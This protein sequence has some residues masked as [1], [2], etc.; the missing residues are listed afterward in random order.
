[1][2]LIVHRQARLL[3]SLQ[4][5]DPAT[6]D[7]SLPGLPLGTTLDPEVLHGAACGENDLELFYPEPGDQA[8]KQA[9]K[10]IC[11]ACPVKDACLEMALAIGDQHAILG[12]TTPAERV[13]MRCC[14][15]QQIH[16]REQAAEWATA[17]T[18]ID[19]GELRA[20]AG[21]SMAAHLRGDASATVRAWE[22]CKS[23]GTAHVAALI[24]VHVTDLHAALAH[25]GLEVPNLHQPAQILEDPVA[26]REAF[27][28]VQQ[29]GWVK[30]ARQV[31]VARRT[32]RAAFG[33]WGMGEPVYRGP[34]APSRLVVDRAV[35]EEALKL[36]IQVGMDQAAERFGVN[37]ATL[38]NAWKRWGLGR[39]TDRPDGVRLARERSLAAK[40]IPDADHPWR[41]DRS[42]WQPRR[43]PERTVQRTAGPER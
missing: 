35:A 41:T 11:A 19:P 13:P 31:G 15:C 40:V 30:A 22:L 16:A 39:P 38:Y 9:A 17:A 6:L 20:P 18:G 7:V 5:D 21:R 36:A 34:C 37:R 43:T 29:V 2:T 23:A 27:G 10:A 14:Q 32:L 4:G 25:W 3:S 24:G 28:L 8:A 33:R 42:I 26:A 1:M 12:G